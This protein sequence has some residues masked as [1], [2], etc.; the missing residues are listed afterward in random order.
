MSDQKLIRCGW[1]ESD[2]LYVDYHDQVWS[3]PVRDDQLLFE[4]LIL[5][6]FQAGLSWITILRK[7][8]A[9][10]NAFD[11]FQPEIVAEYEQGKINELLSNPGI[12]RNRL[13]IHA[14]VTN[15][16][17]FLTV[18]AEFGSFS[19]YIWR[20]SG[21]K[22]IINQF[23]T[24][25]EIPASTAE[26]EEM[27]ADL[28]ARGFKFVGPTICYAFMQAVGMVNDHIMD[29]FRYEQINAMITEGN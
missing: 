1:G 24:L 16:R 29:C 7:R 27:S 18:Q 3:V 21:G 22:T 6:G 13:K 17:A 10:R 23:K 9:F 19:D 28:K 4:F 8:E 12:I 26:S 11:N 2:P 20:F 14:A 25:S 5:E 15:A